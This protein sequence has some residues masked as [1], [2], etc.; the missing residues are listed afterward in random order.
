M[1]EKELTEFEQQVGVIIN[2]NDKH[3]FMHVAKSIDFGIVLSGEIYLMLDKE[4]TRL[5]AGDVVIQRGTNH[6][7]SNRSNQDCKMAY[8]LLDEQLD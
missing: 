5:Q 4:E 6:A 3:P 8:V 1:T 7:W 2:R